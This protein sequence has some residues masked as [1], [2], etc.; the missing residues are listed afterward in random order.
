MSRA[1]HCDALDT[2]HAYIR[3]EIFFTRNGATKMK[4]LGPNSP[5]GALA[6][7]MEAQYVQVSTCNIPA[8]WPTQLD[9]PVA[10]GPK[11]GP[12]GLPEN[13]Q[14]H[15]KWLSGPK[16]GPRSALVVSWGDRAHG[17]DAAHPVGPA[18]GSL[19]QIRPPGVAR[20]PL[21]TPK[22]PFLGQNGS[23]WGPQECRMPKCAIK[24][25]HKKN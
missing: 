15:Q 3:P 10:L 18:N 25:K 11:S 22:G 5:F 1:S 20:G 21:G 17:I 23:F 2:S 16:T 19:T 6:A 12:P 4:E 9:Q 24:K 7:E 8:M 13:L 14:G